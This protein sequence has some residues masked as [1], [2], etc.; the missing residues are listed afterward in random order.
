M[1][2]QA[3]AQTEKA[4][5]AWASPS[6]SR[7]GAAPITIGLVNNMPDS[8]LAATERQFRTLLDAA[9][10]GREVRLKLFFLP[11]I[12]RS[13][14]ARAHMRGAYASTSGLPASSVDALIVTGA[15][16]LGRDLKDEP[17]WN[18]LAALADWAAANTVSTIWSCLAAHAA[19]LRL[20]GIER[21]PLRSKLSGVFPVSKASRHPLLSGQLPRPLVPHSRLNGLCEV[22]LRSKGY[23][24]LTRSDD[25]GVDAFSRQT[26]SLFLFLQGHPEYDADSLALEYRRDVRRF[27]LGQRAAYPDV[28]VGYFDAD[29]EAALRELSHEAAHRQ[30]AGVLSQCAKLIACRPPEQRWSDATLRLY[31]NWVEFVSARAS[32]HAAV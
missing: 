21:R 15:E 32:S 7:V 2:L 25:I 5:K 12:P 24:I 29:T 14:G 4:V 31:R 27:M 8:A 22:E 13:E 3:Q 19:V 11:E 6:A 26:D 18:G 23:T 28:P 30:T 9:S 17:C 16:P 20:D 1:P 10:L